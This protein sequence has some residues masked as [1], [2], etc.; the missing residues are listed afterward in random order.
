MCC[1]IGGRY[2]LR[3]GLLFVIIQ[4]NNISNMY[5]NVIYNNMIDERQLITAIKNLYKKDKKD[6]DE[7]ESTVNEAPILENDFIKIMDKEL[8][9]ANHIDDP[10]KQELTPIELARIIKQK[11]EATLT[12]GGRRRRSIRR[13]ASS[14]RKSRKVR[15]T[16]NARKTRNTRRK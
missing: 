13:R 7:G 15:K 10:S 11:Y 4:K 8:A 3:L 16:R 5:K 2:T 1:G 14:R 6:E 9:A 12:S